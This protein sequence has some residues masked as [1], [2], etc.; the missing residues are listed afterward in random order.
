[1]KLFRLSF[2]D[3]CVGHRLFQGFGNYPHRFTQGLVNLG[4]G[5]EIARYLIKVVESFLW[6]HRAHVKDNFTVLYTRSVQ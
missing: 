2:G 1:M 6:S 4:S 3:G 5:A